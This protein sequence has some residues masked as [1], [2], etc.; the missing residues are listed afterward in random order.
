MGG[1]HKITTEPIYIGIVGVGVVGNSFL[2]ELAVRMPKPPRLILLA[3]SSQALLAS[4]P[5]YSP[6]IPISNWEN[7]FSD[8]SLTRLEKGLSPR[9][10]A[11]YLASAPGRVI[12][13][14]NTSD[15]S[16]A[17]AYPTFPKQGISV[18]T[19]N[20]KAFSQDLSLWSDIFASA[21]QGNSLVHHQCTVGGTLPVL[22]TLR[23]LITAGD[24]ILHVEGVLSGTLSLLFGTYMPDPE[25]SDAKWSSLVAHAR[26]AGETEPDPRGDLNGLDFARKLTIIA[27][28]IGLDVANAESF[29]VESLIPEELRSLPSSAKGVE[30]FMSEQPRF[31]AQMEEAKDKAHVLGK[32]LRY[33]GSIDVPTKTIKV[34][35]QQVDKGTPIAG[36]QG[37]Q[38]VSIYTKRRGE[39]P[40]IFQRGGGG[41]D[42]TAHGL[43]TNLLKMIEKF[44]K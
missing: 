24:E 7:A 6:C 2:R 38:F 35:L 19:P 21:T 34:R 27:R 22:S 11:D 26:E 16:L 1:P 29:P 13:V 8:P 41:G 20:K 40:L 4:T 43:A 18:V 44:H 25:T 32:V 17:Q 23:D 9:E 30:Q 14:D 31:D 3:R 33:I 42:I 12:L 28:V 5:A 37:S 10:I 15:L 36:L 39:A